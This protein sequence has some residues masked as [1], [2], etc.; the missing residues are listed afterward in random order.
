MKSITAIIC[1]AA[2][3]GSLSLAGA[4]TCCERA[5]KEGKE[6]PHKCCIK[7]KKEGKVCERCNPKKEAK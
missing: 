3:L 2:L 1:A 7:A 5:K 4:E 6:C